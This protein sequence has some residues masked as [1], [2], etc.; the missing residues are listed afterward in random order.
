MSQKGNHGE[1]SPHLVTLSHYINVLD[2]PNAT[3][4]SPLIPAQSL[5]LP[6]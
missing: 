1:F 4:N 5:K 6:F 3:P 2:I